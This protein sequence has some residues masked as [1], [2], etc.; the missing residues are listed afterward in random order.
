MFIVFQS[1]LRVVE[2]AVNGSEAI[3]TT[4]NRLNKVDQTAVDYVR[5]KESSLQPVLPN[6]SKALLAQSALNRLS[7]WRPIF[8]SHSENIHQLSGSS[9]F[10]QAVDSL[11]DRLSSIDDM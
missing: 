11:L 1:V 3:T 10:S 5:R 2:S 6:A 7:I 9:A 4:M 8:T